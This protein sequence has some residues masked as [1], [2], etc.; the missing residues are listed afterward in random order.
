MNADILL[1]NSQRL[2]SNRSYS[3]KLSW[4]RKEGVDLRRQIKEFIEVNFNIKL[5]TSW[6]QFKK[7]TLGSKIYNEIKESYGELA[8][9]YYTLGN[10]GQS[11]GSLFTNGTHTEVFTNGHLFSKHRLDPVWNWKKSK[12]IRTVYY[13]FLKTSKIYKQFTP[14][15]ITLTLPHANGLYKGNEFYAKELIEHFNLI[16][17][18]AWWKKFVHAGEYGVET[19]GNS[20]NGLHIHIHS[21]AFLKVEKLNAFRTKLQ[22]AWLKA[23][24]ATQVWVESLYIY[25]KDD[26]NHFITEMKDPSKL[27]TFEQSDGTYTSVPIGKIVVKKKFYIQDEI[28]QIN[29]SNA[30]VDEKEDQI[31]QL[32]TK[33]ILETIKYHFKNDSI[34]LSDGNYNIFLINEILKNTRNK[35]LY[36][37]Y[38]AFYKEPELNFNRMDEDEQGEELNEA[39]SETVINPFTMEETPISETQLVVFYPEHLTYTGR[40]SSRPHTPL[41]MKTNVFDYMEGKSVKEIL[42]TLITSKFKKRQKAMEL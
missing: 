31:L 20:V 17:K 40:L 37:R 4:K 11:V 42:K 21:L 33:A 38:G 12:L 1:Q 36:S 16:R 8:R 15:H 29:Q 34:K 28:K 3:A 41:P 39:N 9:C 23:T 35:R 26:A 18:T 32:H 6:N 19:T 13:N 2:Q 10:Y 25:K 5:P 30:T 7:Y 24:G 22:S 27:E 14:A